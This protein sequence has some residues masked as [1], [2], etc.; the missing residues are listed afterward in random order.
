MNKLPGFERA[1]LKDR[2]IIRQSLVS[3]ASRHLTIC[4]QIRFAYDLVYLLPDNEIR[5]ELTEQLI[6]IFGT[7][8]KIN[9]RL[10]HYKRHFGGDT[11]NGGKNIKNLYS[12]KERKRIRSLRH[13]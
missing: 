7:A 11:G 1:I 8:K 13:I 4:E 6:D 9:A 12:T 3:D 5:L 2:D 10:A